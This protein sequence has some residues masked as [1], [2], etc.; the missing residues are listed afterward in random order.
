MPYLI[1]RL[2][3]KQQTKRLDIASGAIWTAKDGSRFKLGR[4]FKQGFN[5]A[6]FSGQQLDGPGAPRSCAIKVLK[7]LD[8]PREDRFHNEV[9]ILRDLGHDSITGYYGHGTISLEYCEVPWVAMDA[10]D[11]NLREFMD[12]AEAAMDLPCLGEVTL[13]MC[14]ALEHL[15]LKKL[16]HRDVKPDN[17]VWRN[18][19]DYRI[20]MI[21]F[22]IAKR[23]GQDVS[24]RPMD[25]FT[26]DNEQV[27]PVHFFSPELIAYGRN[28]KTLV[29]HRSD[30]FQLGK[31]IWFFATN[32]IPAGIISVK[33]DPTNGPLHAIVTEMLAEDP[34]DRPSSAR[35]VKE[36][37]AKILPMR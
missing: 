28:K 35:E 31:I 12:D 8:S 2:A 4:L 13:Q 6:V 5:G 26:F 30:L 22:G 36:R 33:R 10:G 29:D 11:Q 1:V 34:N 37:I 25:N 15:H 14:E 3:A 7:H 27:G 18:T 9:E 21:D 32:N 16:I 19:S 24:A 23:V 17:F 20:M